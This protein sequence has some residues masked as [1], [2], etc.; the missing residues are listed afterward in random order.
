MEVVHVAAPGLLLT[1]MV[2]VLV[3]AGRRVKSVFNVVALKLL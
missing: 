1:L 3:V 2:A